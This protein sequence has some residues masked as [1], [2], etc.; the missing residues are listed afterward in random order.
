M[1]GQKERR[2]SGSD[3]PVLPEMKKMKATWSGRIC[4]NWLLSTWCPR[5]CA[6]GRRNCSNGVSRSKST[7]LIALVQS[8]NFAEVTFM[9]YFNLSNGWRISIGTQTAPSIRIAI[10]PAT[11]HLDFSTR[12]STLSCY[13]T[14]KATR[15]DASE[16]TCSLSSAYVHSPSQ[17]HT[18]SVSGRFLTCQLQI[19]GRERNS[20]RRCRQFQC[21]TSSWFSRL[22]RLKSSRKTVGFSAIHR[23]A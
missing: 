6:G 19:S 14:P 17:A 8:M 12:S 22:E 7:S 15:R 10:I 21:S 1:M 4:G 23:A 20:G 2:G 5:N 3:L 13:C 18:A 16:W 11:A 9:T